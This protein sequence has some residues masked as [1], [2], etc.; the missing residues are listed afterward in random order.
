MTGGLYCPRYKPPIPIRERRNTMSDYIL[1]IRINIKAN[2]D[3][4]ARFKSKMIVG[5]FKDTVS[6]AKV[7]LREI[8]KG[9]EPRIINLK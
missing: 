5:L 1:Q 9:V 4:E 2:D 8:R 3:P 7:G 6:I